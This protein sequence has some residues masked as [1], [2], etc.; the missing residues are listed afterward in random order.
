MESLFFV[1]N[2]RLFLVLSP[3]VTGIFIGIITGSNVKKGFYI[4]ATCGSLVSLLFNNLYLII[5]F[6][7]EK[8]NIFIPENSNIFVYAA[9]IFVL[10]IT[11]NV[12]NLKLD[13]ILSG[14][15][16]NK[17]IFK[18]FI[19]ISLW[20]ATLLGIQAVIVI[21]NWAIL[22]LAYIFI[23]IYAILAGLLSVFS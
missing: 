23:C 15:S 20:L 21:I 14:N 22:V 12:I 9:M 13:N 11:I 2:D 8:F 17:I 4:G 1:Y 5:G 7:P 3:I 10:S 6:N 19:G 16:V 18:G